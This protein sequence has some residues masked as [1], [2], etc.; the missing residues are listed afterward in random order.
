MLYHWA[1]NPLVNI[2][3]PLLWLSQYQSQSVRMRG[4]EPPRLSA[5]GLKSAASTSFAT[6]AFIFCAPNWIR[7][8]N[9][10]VMSGLLYHWAIGAF[11]F[12]CPWRESN[13][14]AF[15]HLRLKQGRLP[16]PPHR[17]SLSVLGRTRTS[18]PH[19]FK[20]MGFQTRRR[21][22]RLPIS[23]REHLTGI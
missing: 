14:H 8:S 1:K 13:P 20:S 6:P 19:R 22:V 11:V 4:L 15:R 23:P 12:Q 7:T 3:K 10:P 21:E 2:S 5:S 18:T 9:R 16:V 17:H